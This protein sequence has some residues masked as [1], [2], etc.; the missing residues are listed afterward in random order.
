MVPEPRLSDVVGLWPGATW[1]GVNLLTGLPVVTQ[2][3]RRNTSVGT[4]LLGSQSLPSGPDAWIDK[5]GLRVP[6]ARPTGAVCKG[7][8]PHAT[9]QA[10]KTGT[11]SSL[12]HQILGRLTSQKHNLTAADMKDLKTCNM[13]Q[14][15]EVAQ[16]ARVLFDVWSVGG[17][18]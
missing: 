14:K 3:V 5:G 1:R 8:S 12:A 15:G 9:R 17:V 2:P 18:C 6:W 7:P 13:S 11:D 10:G 16:R 4:C